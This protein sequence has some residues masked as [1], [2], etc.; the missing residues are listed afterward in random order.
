F[1]VF[2]ILIGS[3]VAYAASGW[4]FKTGFFP[5]TVAI[6][7]IVLAAAH[8]LL[9]LFGGPEK[10]GGTVAEAEFSQPVSPD[11][12]RCRELAIFGWIAGFIAFVAL[13]GFPLAVPLFVFLY[14]KI[15]SRIG[16]LQT[17]AL[18][19]GTWIAFHLL[20]QRVVQLQFEDGLIQAWLGA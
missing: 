13:I 14:L 10:P 7:L 2:L 15:Q 8:L 16:W 20:F 17:A 5:L 4:S 1:S 18:T 19:A 9:E 12:A 11:V 3:Y 6:P